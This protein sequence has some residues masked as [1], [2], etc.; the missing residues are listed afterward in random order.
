MD[1]KQTLYQRVLSKPTAHLYRLPGAGQ[2]AQQAAMTRFYV[3]G[4]QT[5]DRKDWVEVGLT[6]QG[7]VVGWMAADDLLPWKQQLTLAFTNPAGRQRALF[8][9]QRDDLLSVVE[10]ATPDQV[11]APLRQKIEQGGRDPRVVSIEPATY[12]DISQNFYLLPILE[13]EETFS[14]L[15]HRVRILNV[16][17]VSLPGEDKQDPKQAEPT[18]AALGN[19]SAAVVFVIDSTISMGP[20]IDR[21]REAV[22]TITKRMEAAGLGDQVKFGLVAYRSNVEASPGLEYVTKVYA[23]PA[24]TKDGADFLAKI[25]DLKPATVSSARFSE[26]AFGGVVE[27]IDRIDWDPFG[28]RYVVLITDAGA[29]KGG[30]PLSSTGLS[31]DQVRLEVKDRGLA[32]FAMHLKTAAGAKNHAEAEA[33]YSALS[34]N[35]YLRRSLYYPVNAGSV[36]AF[37]IMVDDLASSIVTQVQA[38]SEGQ[39]A[40]GA[41]A[42]KAAPA[43]PSA[44]QKSD[45]ISL[46]AAALGHAMQLAYLGRVQGTQAPLLFDGWIS[47]RDLA[48]PDV[49]TTEVRVLLTRNQLSN[50]QQVLQS[51]LEAGQAAQLAPDRFFSMIQSA[52]AVMGRDPNAVTKGDATKLAELGLMGEY[53]DDLPYRSKILDIDQQTWSSWSI[54]QQQMFLDEIHRKLRLYAKYN[55]DVDR[56]V[57][58]D[59]GAD[60]GAAVYPVPLDAL[61]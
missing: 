20:Y 42:P 5:V 19:F 50:M 59:G 32:L 3:Y 25:Q 29:L 15:G 40:A 57:A 12:V 53:L 23:D 36:Q 2:G 4:H 8:F 47:D 6:D 38:A 37:G 46:D 43:T 17:S 52:T 27:A 35:D 28:G 39:Q 34:Y 55:G 44:E 49:A 56:W 16:A 58:L 7:D 9:T 31:A 21:T 18:P 1:G 13:A 10:D 11:V 48:Q 41:N 14:G 61:P 51:V 54:S 22:R 26:D 30:D 24:T 45:Q 60:P 33:Q